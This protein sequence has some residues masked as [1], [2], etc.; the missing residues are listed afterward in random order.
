MQSEEL[1]MKARVTLCAYL[2]E[3]INERNRNNLTDAVK[4][5]FILRQASTTQPEFE[6][7]AQDNFHLT[8]EEA[9]HF[10]RVSMQ[11][12]EGL[13]SQTKISEWLQ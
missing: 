5:G 7:W 13:L 8:L 12:E 3:Q 10:M 6:K 9:H 2:L 11:F 1:E 4:V